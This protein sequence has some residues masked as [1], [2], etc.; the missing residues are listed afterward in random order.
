MT[1]TP[2]ERT[3]LS[4]RCADAT[5]RSVSSARQQQRLVGAVALLALLLVIA[6]LLASSAGATNASW[7]AATSGDVKPR[8]HLLGIRLPRALLAGLVGGTLAGRG[9]SVQAPVHNP[10]A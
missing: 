5:L 10:P 4:A 1:S 2:P 9:L 3:R 7:R 6:L 8:Q